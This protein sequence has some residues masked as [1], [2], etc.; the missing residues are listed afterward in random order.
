ME[1]KKKRARYQKKVIYPEFQE[2]AKFTLNNFWIQLLTMCSFGKFPKG[3]SFQD[4]KIFFKKKNI[5]RQFSLP[6]SAENL[7]K[8][9]ISIFREECGL[10]SSQEDK[11]QTELVESER[12][13][14]PDSG[15]LSDIKD[16]NVRFR[17]LFDF[18]VN[19]KIC[20]NL[21]EPQRK[22]L[23]SIISIGQLLKVIRPEN[24][25]IK[26]HKIVFMDHLH[27]KNGSFYL[28]L[29]HARQDSGSK[30]RSSSRK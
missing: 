21:T 4:G 23:H 18:T 12:E 1:E 19:Y 2:A 20:Y 25:E 30:S 11:K 14:I 29:E 15:F 13:I 7:C 3:I 24:I 17:L 28:E 26:N 16:K 27:F 9:M 10:L 5:I 6:N 8:T 22:Q